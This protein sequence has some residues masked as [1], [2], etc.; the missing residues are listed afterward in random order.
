MGFENQ[1]TDTVSLKE[2]CCASLRQKVREEL[3]ECIEL[4]QVSG[5][6]TKKKVLKKLQSLSL[7]LTEPTQK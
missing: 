4:L 1:G 5:E 2:E 6:N 7:H 3:D